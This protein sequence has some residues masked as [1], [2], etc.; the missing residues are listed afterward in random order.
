MALRIRDITEFVEFSLLLK[1][2]SC[3]KRIASL[4]DAE[5]S[6]PSPVASNQPDATGAQ[7]ADGPTRISREP[8]NVRTT[9]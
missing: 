8:L 7:L 9:S 1:Q 5:C 2:A 3:Q 4:A 6:Q